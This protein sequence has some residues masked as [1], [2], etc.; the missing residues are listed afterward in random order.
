MLKQ[1]DFNRYLKRYCHKLT[2]EKL[3]ELVAKL[4]PK[5]D[6][7]LLPPKRL[8]TIFG[9]YHGTACVFQYVPLPGSPAR[10]KLIARSNL[11]DFEQVVKLAEGNNNGHATYSFLCACGDKTRRLF[12]DCDSDQYVCIHCLAKSLTFTTIKSTRLQRREMVPV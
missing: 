4:N 11:G 12:L 1:P 9:P 7:D 2:M 6:E 5:T 10:I 8:I 3:P